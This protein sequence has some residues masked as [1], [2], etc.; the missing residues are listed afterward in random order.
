MLEIEGER[1]AAHELLATEAWSDLQA[2][3]MSNMDTSMDE[4]ATL[5]LQ[6]D[7]ILGGNVSV[8]LDSHVLVETGEIGTTE[9]YARRVDDMSS[10]EI[11]EHARTMGLKR[12]RN[13]DDDDYAVSIATPAKKHRVE[14]TVTISTLS[15]HAWDITAS[16]T[17]MECIREV[18][19]E[20]HLAENEEQLKAL[21]IVAK[22]IIA[23]SRKQLIMFIGGVGGTGKSHVI[24]S[25][26]RLHELLGREAELSLGAPTGIAAILIGGRTLHSL[27]MSSPHSR[28]STA[29]D[30][31][32]LS[33]KWRQRRTLII[34]ESS[35]V[36]ATF[37]SEVSGK[38]RQGKGDNPVDRT[39][40]F[41]GL[42]VIFTGDFGQLK[43]PIQKPLYAHE[44]V[45]DPSFAEGRN[46]EGISAMNGV[47]LWRLVD[48]VVELTQNQRQASDP[49]YSEFLNR[50]RIRKCIQK[51]SS[52][53]KDDLDYLSS[54]ILTNLCDSGENLSDFHDAPII[55]G[56]KIVR[57]ALNA[58]MVVY[59][60]E[61]LGQRAEVYYARDSV[62]QSAAPAGL[63]EYMWNL[64]SRVNKESF[65]KLLLFPGMK[66]MVTENVA[67]DSGIVNGTEGT[68]IRIYYEEDD[69]GRRF[70]KVVH[71]HVEGIGLCIEGLGKDIVPIFPAPRRIEHEI[72]GDS[73]MR[74]T[75]FTRRQLP[76][77]PG[78]AYT[79]FKSQGRSL[80]KAIVDLA[81]ARGQG[82]YVMLSRVRSLSGVIILRWFPASKLY[83]NLSEELRNELSR[84]DILRKATDKV[85][86][87][88]TDTDRVGG[89][90]LYSR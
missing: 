72:I 53:E 22:Q 84:L 31:E 70:A 76:L 43:P 44:I 27:I 18:V 89:A 80:S 6:L 29:N 45:T 58:K 62:R 30:I 83:H 11:A 73:G 59:H 87:G 37:L 55:V 54:R 4:G 39:L 49:Q 78:Y 60:S 77:I 3:E 86:N 46:S 85:Y 17:E 81:T 63:Q 74:I 10:T 15:H 42:N 64:P 75:G 69:E 41:G 16:S 28:G 38:I 8:Y 35:M 2:G 21:L 40:P 65:G 26:V 57:D 33:S 32:K 34:D 7:G 52:T 23:P 67:F 24:K 68:V 61:R 1:I 90:N 79:D 66:V 47:F 48:T 88:D 82:A 56:S 19:A 25:I 12:S 36:G 13:T 71:L 14:A 5:N 20:M 50:L 9:G 51:R